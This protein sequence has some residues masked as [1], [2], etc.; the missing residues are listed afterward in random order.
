MEDSLPLGGTR[1]GTK[2]LIMAE[3]ESRT[4]G[5]SGGENRPEGPEPPKSQESGLDSHSGP[6][7]RSRAAE[8]AKSLSAKS[9]K[10]PSGSVVKDAALLDNIPSSE[11]LSSETGLPLGSHNKDGGAHETSPDGD[12]QTKESRSRGGHKKGPGAKNA[13]KTSGQSSAPPSSSEKTTAGEKSSRSRQNG[14]GRGSSSSRGRSSGGSRRNSSKP[15]PSKKAKED[16]GQPLDIS[17]ELLGAIK[18]LNASLSENTLGLKAGMK[19]GFQDLTA[20]MQENFSR[21]SANQRHSSSEEEEEGEEEDSIFSS[22][23][24][25]TSGPQDGSYSKPVH[26]N[27]DHPISEDEDDQSKSGKET[28]TSPSK[29]DGGKTE[30]P[31]EPENSSSVTGEVKKNS[32][33][34]KKRAQIVQLKDTSEDLDEDLAVILM[35]KFW[36]P[37]VMTKESFLDRMSKSLRPGNVPALQTPALQDCIWRK[38]PDNIRGKD[39]WDK[40]TQSNLMLIWRELAETINILGPHEGEHPWVTDVIEKLLDIFG[41]AGYVNSFNFVNHRREALRPGL[42]AEYKRLAGDGFPPSPEWLFGDELGESVE[43]IT[44][45]NKLAEKIFQK[46][47]SKSQSQPS[48]PSKKGGSRPNPGGPN[49]GKRNKKSKTKGHRHSS[50]YQSPLP[51]GESAPMSFERKNNHPPNAGPK[52]DQR[53]Q[54]NQGVSKT[55]RTF[56]STNL[57]NFVEQWQG[58]TSDPSILEDIKG[59]KID[60]SDLP[61]QYE[62]PR[63]YR[64]NSESRDILDAEIQSLESRGIIERTISSVPGTYVSNVFLRPKPN[65]KHRLILDLSKL[66]DGVVKKHFKMT[67]LETAINLLSRGCYMGSIDLKDAYY[68][69]AIRGEFRKFLC[70]QWGGKMYHFNALPFGLTSA[71]RIFTKILKPVFSNFRDNG[72][73]GFAYLDDSFIIGRT[74][75]ECQEAIDFLSNSFVELGFKIHEEKSVLKSTKMLTF[76]G[77]ILDSDTFTVRPTLGKIEKLQNKIHDLLDDKH[78]SIRQAASAVGLMNDMCKGIDYGLA[79]VKALE[80]DKINSLKKAGSP[81][82]DG[83]FRLS[84][85]G[86]EDLRWWLTNAPVGLRAIRAEGPSITITTDASKLGWGAVVNDSKTG[87]RWSLEESELHINVLELMAIELGLATFFAASRGSFIR[88]VTDNTTAVAYVNHMGGTKSRDCDKVAR[89]IWSWCEA[90]GI[91]LRAAHLPGVENVE[92]DHESRNFTENTEWK[93]NPEIFDCLCKTWGVPEIDLFASRLNFQIPN[94]CSWIPDPGATWVDA[95][96]FKWNQFRLSYAFPPFSLLT[97]S[98]QKIRTEGAKVILVLPNWR[99]QAWWSTAKKSAKEIMKFK[100]APDNLKQC[101]PGGNKDSLADLELLGLLF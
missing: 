6:S 36:G 59:V 14:D 52:K 70:F 20:S 21:L 31:K 84:Q 86:E 76:L 44:K 58:I 23:E 64:F 95:F 90:K 37:N 68:S 80:R 89:R 46:P 15:P 4:D 100:R 18:N 82:F 2:A 87:G 19:E 5:V 88:V 45:E 33:F 3:H 28:L 47:K 43:K 40:L 94:Y 79:H 63:V 49:A 65:G 99:G 73:E 10:E 16:K 54:Q 85:E 9:G 12:K 75:A 61:C 69:V 60:F 27:Q 13:G 66:N 7:L 53:G 78:V 83:R 11:T 51:Q 97:R 22:D 55:F 93:L 67:H 26:V 38:L 77:Y 35:D 98:I 71:P 101:V 24:D 72:H 39:K 42:P 29:S 74:L 34:A 41:L 48:F 81:Q 91:W 57:S 8:I 62:V 92:A 50:E 1:S 30:T 96:S 17:L 56:K 25:Q 32:I